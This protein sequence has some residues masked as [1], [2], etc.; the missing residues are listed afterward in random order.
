[1]ILLS[2]ARRESHSFSLN[3]AVNQAHCYVTLL[4]QLLYG[5]VLGVGSMAY[6]QATEQSRARGVMSTTR[7]PISYLG[8]RRTSGERER[9]PSVVVRRQM[10]EHEVSLRRPMLRRETGI[11][12]ANRSRSNA[13]PLQSP[14]S[15][16]PHGR[17][18]HTIALHER[19]SVC[20]F[21]C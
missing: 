4:I 20:R 9:V 12:P 21:R 3:I 1:M 5:L 2:I 6:T 16:A 10:Q 8:N 14:R 17:C 11:T 15:A 13:P 7:Q 19:V 18:V